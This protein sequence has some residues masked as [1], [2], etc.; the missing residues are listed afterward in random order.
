M[1]TMPSTA[2]SLRP[3]E[4]SGAAQRVVRDLLGA[5]GA[6]VASETIAAALR[7]R[8]GAPGRGRR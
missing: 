2:A 7:E 5:D 8:A 4:R 3:A 6:A 1:P